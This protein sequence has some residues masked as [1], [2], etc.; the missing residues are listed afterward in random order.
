M[1]LPPR[2]YQLLKGDLPMNGNKPKIGVLAVGRATFDTEYAA[3]IFEA[4]WKN[5]QTL[6]VQFSGK[7]TLHYESAPVL[8]DFAKLQSENI[9]MLLVLQVTF[10][11]ASVCAEIAKQLNVPLVLWTFSEER[12]GGRLRLNSFCGVNLA[13]HA[14]SRMQKSLDNVHGKADSKECATAI[15]E[16]AQAAYTVRKLSIANVLVVGDHPTG[17]EACNFDPAELKAKVGVTTK[18]TT[19]IDFIDSVKAKPDSIADAPYARRAKDFANLGEMDKEATTKSLKVY[20][21]LKERADKEN[22]SG[23]A[24]RCWPEMFTHYGCAACGAIGL[25]NEDRIPGGCEADLY[26][27]VSSLTLQLASNQTAFNTD[28]VDIDPASNT[29]VFWHC[30]QAPLDMADPDVAPIAT[31]HTNRKLPLLAQFP[32]KAGRIT[33]CRFTQGH[34]KLKMMLAAGDMI[35]APLAYSGT[36]GVA[37]M[38]ISA[39]AFREKI[40]EIGMEHHCSLTYGDQRPVLRKIARYLGIEVVELT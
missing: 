4:A 5:L 25:L 8:A 23:I 17:F 37:R 18:T 28:L 6:P 22:L 33:L 7:P 21:T 38:D 12:T 16:C 1:L 19:T 20:A 40:L 2:I 34:G 24:V 14:L 31:I 15:L 13:A 35:K 30:G 3:E 29:V 26:G 36:S 9:D 32:L 10:T 27:V 39:D 11:D